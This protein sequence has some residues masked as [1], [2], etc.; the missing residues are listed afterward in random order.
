MIDQN[1]V[2]YIFPPLN[3]LKQKCNCEGYY[4]YDTA[5]VIG[6]SCLLLFL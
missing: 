4:S 2:K 5:E 3:A 1:Q 6:F